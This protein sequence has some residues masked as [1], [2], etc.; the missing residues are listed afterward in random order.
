MQGVKPGEE[1][2]FPVTGPLVEAVRVDAPPPSLADNTADADRLRRALPA[3]GAVSLP[4][5]RLAAVSAAFRKAGFAGWAVANHLERHSEVVDFVPSEPRLPVMAVDLGTT[6]LAAELIDCRTGGLLARAGRPNSQIRFGADILARIHHGNTAAGRAELQE[7]ACADIQALAA[8]LAS[9]AGCAARDIRAL[10]VAGNTTMCHLLLG[11]DP[12]TI[13]REPY[14][15]AANRFDPFPARELGLDLGPHAPVLVLPNIGSYFGGD[16]VA[17]ILATGMADRPE[18]SMLI[19]VGTNAE[20][21]I[22]NQDF[23]VACAGAAGPALEGGIARMGMRAAPGAIER[24]RV[25]PESGEIWFQ[26]IGN[27]PPRGLCGSGIID[28]V[29][30]LFL[31][32]IIDIRGKLQPERHPRVRRIGGRYAFVVA[33]RGEG[34]ASDPVFIDQVELDNVI[35]SKA[36]MYSILTTLVGE[37]GLSFADIQRIYVAGAFGQHIDPRRAV[38]IGMLPDLPA[39]IFTAVG[40]TSL[41]GARR[42]LLDAT[43]RK[44]AGELTRRITYLELNVNHAFMNRFSGARFLPHTDPSL[45]PSV[46]R[47]AA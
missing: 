9:A 20:V 42:L 10:A 37:V 1:E 30:E 17:G 14:I 7:A 27:A 31:A 47:P 19:D 26:T 35:R 2:R 15:P 44:L 25:D 45:F 6:H 11:L 13:C 29:A 34:G 33:E 38:V 5:S 39:G 16:L 18:V 43:A 46:P 21:V 32:G 24:V 8:D 28:L 12:R 4:F 40:N 41:A 36:A 23:L 22:G 3:T